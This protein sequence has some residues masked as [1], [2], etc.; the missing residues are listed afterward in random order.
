MPEI[1]INRAA[2]SLLGLIWVIPVNNPLHVPPLPGFLSGWTAAVL[3][4]PAFAVLQ[5]RR[6]PAIVITHS[7]IYLLLLIVYILLQSLV[8][9]E[10]YPQRAGSH[11]LSLVLA[12]LALLTAASIRHAFGIETIVRW[13]VPFII[14]GSVISACLGMIQAIEVL[15]PLRFFLINTAGSLPASGNAGQSNLFSQ[16]VFIGLLALTYLSATGCKSRLLYPAM[17]LMIIALGLGSSRSV[18][19]YF[20]GAIVFYCLLFGTTKHPV[21][22]FSIRNLGLLLISFAF[23]Q[24]VLENGLVNLS[25]DYR[26]SLARIVNDTGMDTSATEFQNNSIGQRFALWRNAVDITRD[27]LFFGHGTDSFASL[28]YL[29]TTHDHWI[30]S[31]HSH[32]LFL[33][34]L[35]SHGLMGLALLLLILLSTVRSLSN[36]ESRNSPHKMLI[37][38]LLLILLV[39]SMLELPLWQMPFLLVFACLTGLLDEKT[40]VLM[41]GK[42]PRITINLIML[43]GGL[44]C[45]IT[46]WD[47]TQMPS[48]VNNYHGQATDYYHGWLHG[49]NNIY[50][51]PWIELLQLSLRPD[52]A[53]DLDHR[54]EV[55][56]RQYLW[57]PGSRTVLQHAIY[58]ALNNELDKAVQVL[59][60]ALSAYPEKHRLYRRELLRV[61]RS[62]GNNAIMLLL[63]YL[64]KAIPPAGVS[65]TPDAVQA[66][67]D[68][69][70]PDTAHSSIGYYCMRPMIESI[71]PSIRN[72]FGNNSTTKR[73]GNIVSIIGNMSL[74]G[75]FSARSR[76]SASFSLKMVLA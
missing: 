38:S 5:L 52:N 61:H 60:K 8:I 21:Y 33:E 70:M 67:H 22:R 55:S 36:A 50:L 62:T 13:L 3:V 76:I 59:D 42:I 20:T 57:R 30:Y 45:F 26:S 4:I 23:I 37:M 49:G 69:K 44:F 66:R 24:I 19:L 1:T 39:H 25:G 71:A 46:A 32:N 7:G 74:T 63:E 41:R 11:A 47:Y 12:F 56:R 31:S 43:V 16:H 35:V 10:P 73:E 29:N 17:L 2:L 18:W 14:T 54:L 68:G 75:N 34:I 65:T 9:E 51:K 53:A 6:T 40:I 72:R 48:Y 28:N 27:A 64:Q 58:L 15:S